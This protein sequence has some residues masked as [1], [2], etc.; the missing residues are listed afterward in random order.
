MPLGLWDASV[1]PEGVVINW[2]YEDGAVVAAGAA[3]LEIMVA[4]TNFQ[5]DAPV[6]GTLR[7]R[8]PPD[9]VVV[10]GGLLATIG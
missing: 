1:T 3:L 2:F 8:A 5:I 4:K 10:P 9:A 6:A 7:I